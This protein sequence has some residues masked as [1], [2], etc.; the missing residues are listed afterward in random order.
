MDTD[1]TYGTDEKRP[2]RAGRVPRPPGPP[3]PG[4]PPK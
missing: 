3:P 2:P 4:L 1:G